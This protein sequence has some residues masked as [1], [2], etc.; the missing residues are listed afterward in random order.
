MRIPIILAVG[1]VAALVTLL[2]SVFIL[3][4][5]QQ[6]I[7]LEF[8]KPVSGAITDP[9]LHFKL[10]FVQGVVKLDNRSLPYDA[11]SKEF[12]LSDQR[13]LLVDAFARFK[14]EDPLLFYQAVRTETV[15]GTRLSAILESAAREVF[16]KATRQEVLSGERSKLMASIRSAVNLDAQKLGINVLD[17]RIKRADLPRQNLDSVYK[18]IRTEREQEAIKIR[19]GGERLKAEIEADAD[20]QVTVIL[21]T[22]NK[23]ADI[24]KG[25]GD[26]EALG[27]VNEVLSIEPDFYSFYRSLQAYKTTFSDGNTRIIMSPDSRFFEHFN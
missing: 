2:N 4:E 15:A 3:N 23:D 27:I 5:T 13:R 24:A 7:V 1:G 22:A 21:A 6:A 10:P 25:E 17:V 9:G 12:N 19:S 14:I 8:G 26:A 11:P 18:R 20:R 16:G